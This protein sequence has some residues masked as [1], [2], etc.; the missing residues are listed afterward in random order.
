M[1]P[2]QSLAGLLARL[3]DTAHAPGLLWITFTLV[4]LA[5]G[6]S[7][8]RVSHTEG[9]E[10]TAFTLVG[11]TVQRGQSRSPGRTTWSGSSPR[12]SPCSTRRCGGA[13]PAAG[14]IAR[15]RATPGLREPIW[16]PALDRRAAC[17]RGARALRALPGLA[18]LAVR[19]PVPG[20]VALRRRPVRR[21]HGELVR[22][23]AHRAGGRCCRTGPAPSPRSARQPARQIR[24]PRLEPLVPRACSGEPHALIRSPHRRCPTRVPVTVRLTV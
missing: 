23:R 22:D 11:L 2:N 9:D 17:G 16:F 6:L 20:R 10:L 21:A 13:A 4:L 19:A 5:I 14:I 8:A 7:R 12:S 24:G 1:T 15:G 18:D 3:H